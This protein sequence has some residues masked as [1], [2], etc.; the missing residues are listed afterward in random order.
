MWHQQGLITELF[1]IG[2]ISING[3]PELSSFISIDLKRIVSYPALLQQISDSIWHKISHHTFDLLCGIPYTA[4]PIAT[5]ISLDH[6]IPMVLRK[7]SLKENGLR[8]IEGVFQEGQTCLVVEDVMTSGVSIEETI[9]LLEEGKLQVKDIVVFID[10]DQ[11]GKQIL[12]KHGY[13]LH[14]VFTLPQVI[15][16]LEK[17]HKI[18]HETA[19]KALAFIRDHQCLETSNA[20]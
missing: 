4:L 17:N 1:Q 8:K 9:T 16:I 14:S 15:E 20:L 11:G 3:N 5:A 18:D 2:A 7:K 10:R 19:L 12:G 6:Q 13:H